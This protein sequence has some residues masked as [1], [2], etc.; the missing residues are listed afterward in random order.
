MTGMPDMAGGTTRTP[1]VGRTAGTARTARTAAIVLAAGGGGRYAGPTHKLLATVGCGEDAVPLVVRS[2]GAAV[3]AM[4][5]TGLVGLFVVTGAVDLDDVLE[6]HALAESVVIVPN[7]AWRD[8]LATSLHAGLERAA[9]VGCEYAVIGLAD[10]PAISP[11]DWVAAARCETSS[12]VAVTRWSDGRLTPPVR[13]HRGVW[14]ELPSSGDVGARALWD[15]GAPGSRA[16]IPRPGSGLDIDT[17]ADLDALDALEA[18][19]A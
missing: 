13:L 5:A 17:A 10:M 2:V 18:G 12:Q 11:E 16:E 6:E 9:T 15:T 7:P 8:G 1:E 4:S 19:P 3:A 14:A